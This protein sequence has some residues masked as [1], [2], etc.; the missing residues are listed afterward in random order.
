VKGEFANRAVA[1]CLFSK[2]NKSE[3]FAVKKKEGI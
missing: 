3:N 2:N 1:I